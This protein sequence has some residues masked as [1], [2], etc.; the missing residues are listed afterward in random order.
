MEE[1]KYLQENDITELG[2]VEMI[3]M[4][5]LHIA[6]FNAVACRIEGI[7][8]KV[9]I[10]IEDQRDNDIGCLYDL[11]C[12]R[13]LAMTLTRV[14]SMIALMRKNAVARVEVL[15]RLTQLE[16][17]DVLI[18]QGIYDGSAVE[19]I[20]G[21]AKL[22]ELKMEDLDVQYQ[23][24]FRKAIDYLRT[25]GVPESDMNTGVYSVS[26]DEDDDDE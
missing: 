18:T 4:L 5:Y 6:G 1:V 9:F 16:V 20:E 7:D 14:N 21:L 24:G 10:T 25:L 11:T 3:N 23:I 8:D 19:L 22:M 17:P 13:A 2:I 12:D 26:E 15:G